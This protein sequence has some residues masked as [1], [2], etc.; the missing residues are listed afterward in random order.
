MIQSVQRALQIL[1]FLAVA[2]VRGESG[3]ALRDIAEYMQL[4]PN[5]VHNILKTMVAA[6]YAQQDE[7]R[8]YGLGR[9]AGTLGGSV[10]FSGRIR[11]QVEAEV[12]QFVHAVG[13]SAVL[14]IL[15]A[16][17]R[18]VVYRA[19]GAEA[20]RVDPRADD[21]H[22]IYNIVT[23]R[24]LTAYASPTELDEIVERVG[25]PGKAWNGIETREELEATLAE[26][27]KMGYTQTGPT[28]V[29]ATSLAVPVGGANSRMT[30]A[31][32]LSMPSFRV[33]PEKL[34]NALQALQG[35]ANAIAQVLGD[36]DPLSP[37]KR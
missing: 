25:L 4:P 19:A 24:I 15:I 29:D 33:T 26:V 8:R 12:R 37:G 36:S 28:G 22:G 5:T 3:V 11:N 1:D 21:G 17:R 30:I 14:T 23:G 32:G 6:G 27:R 34:R 16:G 9:H 31:L 13:E 18:R 10:R 35:A 20:V 2:A 7:N